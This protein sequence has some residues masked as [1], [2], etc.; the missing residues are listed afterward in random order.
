MREI[1]ADDLYVASDKELA[2][3]MRKVLGAYLENR[4]LGGDGIH[5]LMPRTIGFSLLFAIE[6]DEIKIKP[7]LRVMQ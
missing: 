1:T 2:E 5:A 3:I 4:D 7:K 6:Q